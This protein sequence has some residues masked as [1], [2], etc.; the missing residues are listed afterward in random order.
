MKRTYS[1]A[2]GARIPSGL[3]PETVAGEL[4]R[5]GWFNI[6]AVVADAKSPQSPLHACFEWDDEVA[7]EKYRDHQARTLIDSVLMTFDEGDRETE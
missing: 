2:P 4:E 7:A 6:P 3:A 5:L 1:F